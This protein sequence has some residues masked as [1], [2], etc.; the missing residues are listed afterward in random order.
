MNNLNS[1]KGFTLIELMIAMAIGLLL[2]SAVITLYVSM[3]SSNIDY[4]KS[5]RLNHELRSAMNL[6][7]RDIRRAGHNQDAATESVAATSINP[8]SNS[9]ASTVQATVLSVTGAST[10][11][12]TISFSYD[13][14]DDANIDTFGYRL[15]IVGGIGAIQYCSNDTTTT[16]VA[17]TNWEDLTDSNLIDIDNLDFEQDTLSVAGGVFTIRQVTI[18]VTGHLISDTDFSKTLSEVVKIRNDHSPNWAM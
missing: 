18:T 17:C 9:S 14:D 5:I 15:N 16:G 3:S 1:N 12:R 4:L 8:F 7:V 11:D 13:S 6:M 10:A 2:V